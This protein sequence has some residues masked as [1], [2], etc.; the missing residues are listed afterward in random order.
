MASPLLASPIGRLRLI[1]LLEGA[2]FLLLLG[3][4]MPLKYMLGLPLAVKVV[5]WLHGALFVM[6]VYALSVAA[7]EASWPF[8]RVV[9]V[10]LSGLVPFGP[11]LMDGRLRRADE[12]A[13]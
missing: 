11:F 2:S 5:G 6:F 1:A 8:K 12:D 10:F 4:A 9:A 3:V 7:A 13:H